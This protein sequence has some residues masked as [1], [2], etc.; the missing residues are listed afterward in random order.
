MLYCCGRRGATQ[1]GC[2]HA[3]GAAA[4]ADVPAAIKG[5]KADG[6]DIKACMD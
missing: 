1:D 3:G 6:N 5:Y 2:Y 4:A